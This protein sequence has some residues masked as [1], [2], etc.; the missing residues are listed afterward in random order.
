M[1]RL[2]V[3]LF[4]L[5]F[6]LY[7][8]AQQEYNPFSPEIDP[9]VQQLDSLYSSM[10]T[11]DPRFA[12][13]ALLQQSITTPEQLLPHFS[14]SELQAKL[15]KIPA[16]FPLTLTREVKTCIET[17]AY[18]KRGLIARCLA[19]SQIYFPIFEEILDRKGLPDEL[20]YLPIVESAFNP[21]AVS[22]AGATGLWQIMHGTATGL[23]LEIN[24]YIDERR[25][26]VRSTE[27]AANFLQKLFELYGDW[28]LVLAAY[29]SGPG[30]VNKAIARSGGKRTFWEI[31]HHLPRETRSYVP[32]YIAAVFVMHYHEDYKILSAKPKRDLYALD[33]VLVFDKISLIQVA[34]H[35]GMDYNELYAL[36]PCYKTGIIPKS[37]KGYPL[38]LPA[39]YLGIYEAKKANIIRDPSMA[40]PLFALVEETEAKWLIHRVK[41]NETISKI[42]SRFGV[43][44]AEIK[45]WNRLRSSTLKTGQKLK[46]QTWI[47]KEKYIAQN[48]GSVKATTPQW[49]IPPLSSDYSLYDNSDPTIKM[50]DDTIIEPDNETESNV[51]PTPASAKKTYSLDPSC[52]CII[53]TVV[54]GDTLMQIANRYDGLTLDKLRK[55]NR[56]PT[57][58]PI[59]IGQKLKIY[60]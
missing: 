45:K 19:N 31:M 38:S 13:D 40:D 28:Q 34:Q 48:P 50:E 6:S 22:R 49:T 41:K 26:P 23:G 24:S 1:I 57:N 51:E 8:F 14:D 4:F 47:N 5:S 56:L 12:D 29:N 55:D 18:K 25:D 39:R 52:R 35:T 16:L 32:L 37:D 2:R 15:K 60:L 11:R 54:K 7:S 44:I 53:Y 58:K 10:F 9:V 27:A 43:S 17:F 33:T 3:F 30:N 59:Q 21:T 42:A 36:N 46:I 20:K